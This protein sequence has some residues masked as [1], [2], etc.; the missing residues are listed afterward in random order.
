MIETYLKNGNTILFKKLM[1]YD[2]I[3]NSS[4]FKSKLNENCFSFIYR[5]FLYS[6]LNSSK[7]LSFHLRYS[8]SGLLQM[9]IS[10][11]CMIIYSRVCLY[12]VWLA[13]LFNPLEIVFYLSFFSVSE[14]IALSLMYC[15]HP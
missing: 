9:L 10:A 14:L 4:F 5:S 3:L 2:T 13:S 6:S 1:F 15:W 12:L 11:V 7:S 8:W